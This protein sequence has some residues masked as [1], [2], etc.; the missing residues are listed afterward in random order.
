M[1]PHKQALELA[2]ITRDEGKDWGHQETYER[3]AN[4]NL[5]IWGFGEA[6][7]L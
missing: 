4:S 1:D 7:G 5:K 6:S 3:P 2:R